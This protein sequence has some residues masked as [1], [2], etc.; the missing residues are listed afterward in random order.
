MPIVGAVLHLD[1]LVVGVVDALASKPQ[2]ELGPAN[3]TRQPVVSCTDSRR[4]DKALWRF[5]EALPGV[6]HV[7]LAFA[8]FSD[9]TDPAGCEVSP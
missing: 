6:M 4:E 1:P 5:I 7:E 8:D 3:G 2:L 9:L